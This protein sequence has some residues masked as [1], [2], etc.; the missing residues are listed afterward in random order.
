M[1]VSGLGGPAQAG[2]PFA[3]FVAHQQPALLRLAF[4]LAGERGQAEDLVRT[5]LV[6]THRHWDRI[7]RRG[8]PSAYVRRALVTAHLSRRRRVWR[9]V[10]PADGPADVVAAGPPGRLDGDEALLRALLG[11]PPR[12]RATLVLR[13]Y[14]DLSELQTAQVMGCSESTVDTQAARGLTRL[15]NVLGGDVHGVAR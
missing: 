3:D 13:Y 4:L 10:R 5:A 2:A 14:E 15:R 1:A 9:R 6:R 7:V 12:M 11:L 8:E